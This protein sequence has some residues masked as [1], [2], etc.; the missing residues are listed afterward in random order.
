MR[1]SL[2]FSENDVL[3]TK[4]HPVIE[5][6]EIDKKL[7]DEQYQNCI[8]E[9][10]DSIL[11]INLMEKLCKHMIQTL[12]KQMFERFEANRDLVK[13]VLDSVFE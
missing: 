5:K 4:Y 13:S 12:G 3:A 11:G 1:Y 9:S 8:K 2:Y 10:T 6:G 7:L